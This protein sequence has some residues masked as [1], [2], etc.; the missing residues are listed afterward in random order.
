MIANQPIN[1]LPV[2][3]TRTT[4]QVIVK[5]NGVVGLS[6]ECGTLNEAKDVAAYK[7]EALNL[8][9]IHLSHDQAIR[10]QPDDGVYIAEERVT[11][12]SVPLPV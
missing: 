1:P 7:A 6:R 5:Q 3:V 10:D 9:I 8:G 11:T 12:V 4:F 2:R